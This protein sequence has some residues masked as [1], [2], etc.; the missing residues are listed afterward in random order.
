MGRPRPAPGR[1]DLRTL[2]ARPLPRL[3]AHDG[4][5]VRGGAAR[6]QPPRRPRGADLARSR[7]LLR[8]GRVHR[9][10]PDGSLGVA[11]PAD[12]APRG[13]GG[14]RARPRAR[15][16]GHA[17]A[18]PVPGARDARHRDLPRSAAE[19]VRGADRRLHGPDAGQARATRVERAGRGP[20][21]VLPHAGRRRR[22]VPAGRL[23][24]AL[25]GGPGPARAQGQR[26]GGRGHGGAA[27]VL[28]DARVRL[29]RHVRRGGGVCLHVGD[30]VR[31]TGLVHREPVDHLAGRPG[32]RRAR[33]VVRTRARRVVRHVRAEHLSGRQRRG[34]RR[35]LRPADHRGDVRGPDGAGRSG[36][37]LDQE[38]PRKE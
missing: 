22:G 37:A 16:A 13:G 36:R 24:A 10:H 26:D 19:A 28:Q 23:A 8:R 32:R 34:A 30:R 27:V 20:V 31:L 25:A 17:A 4:A 5:G 9:R 11:V 3:P 12:P 14:V 7:R 1:R 6:A 18:R 35:H 33:L 21:A 2:P 38:I 29:E 15:R